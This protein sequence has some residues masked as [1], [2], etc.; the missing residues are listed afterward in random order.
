MAPPGSLRA[1]AAIGGA[2]GARGST[3]QWAAG[4][5]RQ[6]CGG[7][8]ARWRRRAR[9]TLPRQVRLPGPPPAL[10]A[11]GGGGW[12]YAWSGVMGAGWRPLPPPR[13]A[14]LGAISGLPPD[15]SSPPPPLRPAPGDFFCG[16]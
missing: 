11:P 13:P 2:A 6:A 9:G 16:L 10:P 15:S 12:R 1:E 4:V 8:P 7:C 3:L 5:W 14:P